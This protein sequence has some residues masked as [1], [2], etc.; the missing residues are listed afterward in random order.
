MFQQPLFPPQAAG[1][2][3]ELAVFAEHPMA[4][5]NDC[6]GIFAVR[7]ADGLIGVRLSESG[8]DVM[9]A[10][11]LSIRNGEQAVP[12]LFLKIRAPRIKPDTEL[13]PK[14]LKIFI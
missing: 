6:N 7:I 9:I 5:D 1:I 11:G 13:S 14:P 4:G 8:R 2:A 3:G 12:D 10:D